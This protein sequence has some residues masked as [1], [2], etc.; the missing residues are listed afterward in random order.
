MATLVAW[1][2]LER[3]GVGGLLPHAPQRA[4]IHPWWPTGGSSGEYFAYN[5][6]CPGGAKGT[7]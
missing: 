4:E 7:A 6:A 2:L 5:I 3:D 1:T